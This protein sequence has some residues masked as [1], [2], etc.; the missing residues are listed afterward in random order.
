M[1]RIEA[2][3][4]VCVAL[5]FSPS[6]LSIVWRGIGNTLRNRCVPWL[7]GELH[8]QVRS[9]RAGAGRAGPWPCGACGCVAAARRCA[10]ARPAARP[11]CGAPHKG[12]R[13]APACALCPRAPRRVTPGWLHS[14]LFGWG[15]LPPLGNRTLCFRSE[16]QILVLGSACVVPVRRQSLLLSLPPLG[17]QISPLTRAVMEEWAALCTGGSR[18]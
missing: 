11:G 6:K 15:T 4:D 10:E 12:R 3:K 1:F 2:S 13:S 9:R 7:L 8:A 5:C 17:G 16:G 14:S 18:S